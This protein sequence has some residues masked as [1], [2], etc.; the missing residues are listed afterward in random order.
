[1]RRHEGPF[2]HINM[3]TL[4]MI[5]KLHRYMSKRGKKKISH[6]GWKNNLRFEMSKSDNNTLGLKKSDNNFHILKKK[7]KIYYLLLSF[8]FSW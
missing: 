2:L 4:Q 6:F 5:R 3:N 7:K 8:F 1:M